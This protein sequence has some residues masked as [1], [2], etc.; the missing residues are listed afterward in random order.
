MMATPFLIQQI[1]PNA[2]YVDQYN[3][4][5]AYPTGAKND[6]GM[7]QFDMP[8]LL[9]E[10]QV[11]DPRIKAAELEGLQSPN[12]SVSSLF[13]VE[14]MQ[15]SSKGADALCS[16]SLFKGEGGVAENKLVYGRTWRD[17]VDGLR[18]WID[19][20]KENF[21]NQKIRVY[22]ANDMWDELHK[23][24]ILQSKDVDFIKMVHSDNGTL[25]GILWRYLALDDYNFEYVYAEDIDANGAFKDNYK[26]IHRWQIKN[27]IQGLEKRLHRPYGGPAQLAQP[28]AVRPNEFVNYPVSDASYNRSPE[29]LFFLHSD[30]GR[31]LTHDIGTFCMSWG[32]W[33]VRGP[34]KL[35]CS[36]IP[37]ICRDFLRDPTLQIYNPSKA[38]WS[39]FYQSERVLV[40]YGPDDVFPFYLTR[41]LDIKY[42]LF[43]NRVEVLQAIY[44]FYGED[45]FLLR[46]YKQLVEEGTYFGYFVEGDVLREVPFAFEML[47]DLGEVA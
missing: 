15:L 16:F 11:V 37:L 45:C 41:I 9:N 2:K 28:V 17:Y 1:P 18:H 5:E 25:V 14:D 23:Q 47:K 34:R 26:F 13:D 46:L 4:V 8:Q 42:S 20:Y 3:L 43:Q 7:D 10:I 38:H 36:I 39:R 40:S 30:K 22:V 27:S 24:G 32:N 6:D 12:P 35:P 29:L 31:V 21:P 33:M 44:K 19:F